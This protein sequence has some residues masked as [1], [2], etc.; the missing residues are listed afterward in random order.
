MSSPPGMVPAMDAAKEL[1]IS[2]QRLYQLVAMGRLDSK[3]IG[4]SLFIPRE[5]LDA[6]MA[7]RHRLESNDCATAREVA[8]FFGVDMSTVRSWLATGKLT[9]TKINNRLCFRPNDI[10]QFVPPAVPGV[11]VSTKGTRTLHG[12]Y[13]PPPADGK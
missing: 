11:D 4:R 5:S 9:A 7:G 12:R 13:Y 8:E 6:R 2:R 1:G 10:I 3:K